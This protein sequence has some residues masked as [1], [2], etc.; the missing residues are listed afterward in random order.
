[1][2]RGKPW[3]GNPIAVIRRAI[4]ALGT[5]RIKKWPKAHYADLVELQT[6]YA[7]PAP[8]VERLE[9]NSAEVIVVNALEVGRPPQYDSALDEARPSA[10]PDDLNHRPTDWALGP[11]C[12][13]N[14]AIHRFA[15]LF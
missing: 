15:S 10:T 11:N 14:D 2:L 12:S 7:R 5:V 3:H 8:P 1:M 9:G 4:L 13:A 6:L